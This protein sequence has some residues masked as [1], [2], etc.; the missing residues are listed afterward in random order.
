LSSVGSPSIPVVMCS[1]VSN[2]RRSRL[3]GSC[4]RLSKR[5]LFSKRT[6][7]S[8]ILQGKGA[9]PERRPLLEPTQHKRG[10]S[11]NSCCSRNRH[12]LGIEDTHRRLHKRQTRGLIAA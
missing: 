6:I 12:E 1:S 4:R 3:V 11:W 8:Y 7:V 10:S 5:P 9:C 2:K